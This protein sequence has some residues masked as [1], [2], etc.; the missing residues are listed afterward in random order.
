MGQ[1]DEDPHAV[2]QLLDD[3]EIGLID[4]SLR[5]LGD[6]VDRVVGYFYAAM[7]VEAPQL[8]SLFPAAMDTQRDRLF[9]A[10][11]GAVGNLAAP[12]RLTEQLTALGRDHRKYGVRAE[13]YDVVGRAL[14]TALRHHHE[15]VLYSRQVLLSTTSACRSPSAAAPP[16]IRVSEPS[17]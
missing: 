5:L 13:H 4:E 2:P 17:G 1:H 6:Q 16:S 7:F 11:T 10:L 9:R 15:N 3:D 14:V 12:E 8:R